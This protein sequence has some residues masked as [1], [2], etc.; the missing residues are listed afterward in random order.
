M[1]NNPV[2]FIGSSSIRLWPS[3]DA[4]PGLPVVNRGFGG[5]HISDV[6]HYYDVLVKKQKP[7]VIV[8]YC[9]DNDVAAGKSPREV[10]EDFQGFVE[11][12][13]QDLPAT[14]VLF[15]SIKPSPRRWEHWPTMDEAN[16]L[17]RSYIE[18]HERLHFVDVST[19]MLG[20]NG[21]PRPEI[22]VPD[23]LHLN[24]K[25]YE[26]WRSILEADLTTVYGEAF[27]QR[28]KP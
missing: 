22:F 14:R 2:L 8:F 26:L 19:A 24:E 18:T 3:A 21:R 23:R 13:E 16:G 25:G 11:L 5:A 6:I 1:P 10:L 15:L 4:F 9:G 28:R 7:M 20:A 27:Q 12:L 17:I